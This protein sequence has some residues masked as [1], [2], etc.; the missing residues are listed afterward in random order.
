MREISNHFQVY[1]VFPFYTVKLSKGA[2]ASIPCRC[3]YRCSSW[4]DAS[5][6][7]ICKHKAESS[8]LRIV[9]LVFC[10]LFICASQTCRVFTPGLLAGLRQQRQLCRATCW[11]WWRICWWSIHWVSCRRQRTAQQLLMTGC[12]S[13]SWQPVEL[14]IQGRNSSKLKPKNWFESRFVKSMCATC[15]LFKK[16]FQSKCS[17]M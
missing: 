9:C 6:T 1:S 15:T 7:N 16:K 14:K 2:L 5:S 12:S 11:S 3:Y 17:L 10:F 8:V 4:H 13:G